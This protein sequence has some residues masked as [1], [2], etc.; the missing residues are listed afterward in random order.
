[1]NVNF[2]FK[3]FICTESITEKHPPSVS[4]TVRAHPNQKAFTD[5][6]TL[7]YLDGGS[8]AEFWVPIPQAS[9]NRMVGS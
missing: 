9:P 1:M 2:V 4:G 8:K 5:G 3:V 7:I 6:V